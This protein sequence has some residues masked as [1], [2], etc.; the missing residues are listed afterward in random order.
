[1]NETNT[2]SPGREDRRFLN[3]PLPAVD[4]AGGGYVGAHACGVWPGASVVPANTINSTRRSALV[5]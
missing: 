4:S 5:S 3:E 1:M 2:Y